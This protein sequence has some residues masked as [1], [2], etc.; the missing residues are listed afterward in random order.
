MLYPDLLTKKF[1]LNPHQLQQFDL[2]YRFLN[3]ENKKYNL[4][5]LISLS[6]VYCKHFYDS[7][8]LKEIL[9]FNQIQNVCDV[10][11]GAGFPSFPLKIIYPNLKITIVESSLKKINFLKQLTVVLGLKNICFVHQRAE[12]H[13]LSYDCVLVRALGR[14]DLILKWCRLLIKKNGYFVAMKGKKYAEELKD[15][16]HIIKKIK[17]NLIKINKQE[18]PNQLGTRINLLFQTH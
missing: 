1:K 4:T 18:L 6:D 13:T 14:L 3:Q 10:G 5:A 17:M 7:L 16:Q 2:Y 8:I 9:D 12:K 15:S 11:S